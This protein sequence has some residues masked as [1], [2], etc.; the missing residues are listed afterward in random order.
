MDG[1]KHLECRCGKRL[2]TLHYWGGKVTHKAAR[3]SVAGADEIPSA[4]AVG[5]TPAY[6]NRRNNASPNGSHDRFRWKCRRCFAE[7]VFRAETLA[8]GFES[9]RDADRP[10]VV[11]GLDL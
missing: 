3:T 5:H 4:V 2:D 7:H 10:S 11:V 8:E 1:V 9:A 6:F